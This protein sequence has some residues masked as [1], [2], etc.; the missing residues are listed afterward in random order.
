[1]IYNVSM[2]KKII[3]LF[4][5]F[6]TFT[7]AIVNA[8]TFERVKARHI[9]VSTQKEAIEIKKDLDEGGSFTYWAKYHSLCPSGQNGG[10]LGWFGRG[11][12]VKPFEDAAFSLPI[13]QYSEPIQTQ[14]GWHIIVVD[15]RI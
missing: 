8:E 5:V 2:F 11:Q 1:M 15:D 4:F 12:M 7:T 3:T 6:L 13:G 14:F 10:D 9:L